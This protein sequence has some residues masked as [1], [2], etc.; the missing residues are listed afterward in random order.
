MLEIVSR[1]SQ[2]P[3]PRPRGPIWAAG[4][5]GEE[6]RGVPPHWPQHLPSIPTTSGMFDPRHVSVSHS[7][8]LDSCSSFL[9]LYFCHQFFLAREHSTELCLFPINARVLFPNLSP[10]LSPSHPGRVCNAKGS[11]TQTPTSVSQFGNFIQHART[12]RSPLL[13]SSTFSLLT[14]LLFHC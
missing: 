13:T 11:L 2:V 3:S 9:L 7:H 14:M 12:Y 1:P 5:G 4:P 8:F 10:P 6:T